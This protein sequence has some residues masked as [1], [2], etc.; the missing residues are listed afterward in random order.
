MEIRE[1]KRRGVFVPDVTQVPVTTEEEVLARLRRG[2]AFWR[3]KTCWRGDSSSVMV[4][5]SGGHTARVAPW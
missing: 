3:G 2:E 4:Q 5:G 1:D